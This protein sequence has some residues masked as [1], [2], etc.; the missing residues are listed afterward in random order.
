MRLLYLISLTIMQLFVFSASSCSHNEEPILPNNN[1]QSP[2]NN[3]HTGD[4]VRV[5]VGSK[6][7]TV[8]LVNTNSAK[9]FREILPLEID[10]V[11][12]NNNEKYCNLPNSLPTNSS[13]PQTIKSGDLMLY[14]SKT[15]VLFYKSFSTPYSYTQLGAID[16]VTGLEEALGA[17]NVIV[18]FETE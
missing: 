12:L 17:G 16:D 18:K 4:K 11:E 6:I 3:A 7:F 15:L 5:K 9:A 8:T 1:T 14:G 2:G 10:M 13:K